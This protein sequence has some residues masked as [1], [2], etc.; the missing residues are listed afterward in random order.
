MNG[1]AMNSTQRKVAVETATTV[2]VS[3]KPCL[4]SRNHSAGPRNRCQ[5][6]SIAAQAPAVIF[7]PHATAAGSH[8]MIPRVHS[9]IARATQPFFSLTQPS[10]RLL[11]SLRELLQ[12]LRGFLQRLLGVYQSL[13]EANQSLQ[14]AEN[15]QFDTNQLENSI[16]R[17][18]ANHANHAKTRPSPPL[19]EKVAAGRMRGNR[20]HPSTSIFHVF[21]VFRGSLP[22]SNSYLLAANS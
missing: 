3:L 12:P 9:A 5:S 17:S 10:R 6:H 20:Y 22:L 15:K 7:Q 13:K 2:L 16:F 4:V 19:G 11:Q 18:T 21:G 8:V 1:A 14:D